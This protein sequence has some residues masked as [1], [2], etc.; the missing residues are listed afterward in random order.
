MT[1]LEFSSVKMWKIGDKMMV[2]GIVKGFT[3]KGGKFIWE[4]CEDLL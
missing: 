4:N 3:L 1:M 2:Y